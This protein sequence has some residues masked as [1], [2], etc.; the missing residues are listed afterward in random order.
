MSAMG[1]SGW[2][3]KEAGGLP[4]ADAGGGGYH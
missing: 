2:N 1:H 4:V 3:S